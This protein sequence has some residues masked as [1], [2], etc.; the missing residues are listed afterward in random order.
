VP[1]LNHLRQRITRTAADSTD[2][3][4]GIGFLIRS[5]SV[6]RSLYRKYAVEKGRNRDVRVTWAS[7]GGGLRVTRGVRR[8]AFV[9]GAWGKDGFLGVRSVGGLRATPM[10]GCDGAACKRLQTLD[11]LRLRGLG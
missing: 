5:G 3:W 2:E 6:A 7:P 11:Y 8:L 4:E 1:E 10:Q 9:R